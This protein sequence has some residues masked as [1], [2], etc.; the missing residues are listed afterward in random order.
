MILHHLRR[1]AA[2]V[3]VGVGVAVQM[4]APFASGQPK[5]FTTSWHE[6]WTDCFKETEPCLLAT[7]CPCIQ[8]AKNYVVVNNVN[9]AA[10]QGRSLPPETI[11]SENMGT[12]CGACCIYGTCLYF[13]GPLAM[14][15]AGLCNRGNLRIKY[16]ITTGD[17][18]DQLSD[19]CISAWCPC[20]AL[21][22]EWRELNWRQ[23]QPL[24][25]TMPGAVVGGVM[26][27]PGQPQYQ[28]QQAQYGS[29]QPQY[30]QPQQ[31]YAQPQQP[32]YAQQP[33]QTYAQA[34]M[35]QQQQPMYAAQP[36]YAQQPMYA[37]AQPVQY[38]QYPPQQQM[39]R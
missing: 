1:I 3:G 20:C 2:R 27:P 37:Q 33:Q 5:V 16:N 19:C 10:A 15:I 31:Q 35:Q 18:A 9:P 7:F 39:Q 26:P 36:Q 34:P 22:Q 13:G 25:L 23:D 12:A 21:S 4:A 24:I 6:D 11:V 17:C 30:A 14:G 32:M 28:P 38:Q 29:P 8:F